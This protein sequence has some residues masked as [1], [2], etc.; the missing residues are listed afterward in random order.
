MHDN[1]VRSKDPSALVRFHA[2]IPPPNDHS[3]GYWHVTS[4]MK[5]G[6]Q[7]DMTIFD[8]PR[9]CLPTCSL[10]EEHKPPSG[11]S[12]FMPWPSITHEHIQGLRRKMA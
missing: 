7:P 10:S 12:T 4:D 3:H 2:T 5:K 6:R 8:R 11:A 1:I 9:S